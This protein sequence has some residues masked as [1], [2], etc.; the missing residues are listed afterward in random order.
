[1][2]AA[3]ANAPRRSLAAPIPQRNRGITG[4]AAGLATKEAT[5]Q[6]YRLDD[7][8]GIDGECSTC[9]LDWRGIETGRSRQRCST[10]VAAG[11]SQKVALETEQVRRPVSAAAAAAA[12]AAI[13]AGAGHAVGR[14]GIGRSQLRAQ[15]FDFLAIRFGL[16][17][18]GLEVGNLPGQ[19]ANLLAVRPGLLLCLLELPSEAGYLVAAVGC[20]STASDVNPRSSGTS[21]KAALE[22][23][24]L[25][26]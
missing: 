4:N 19:I 13:G 22:L 7:V 12:A 20:T 15:V 8:L 17:V 23:G 11:G 18:L 16:H 5:R 24:N 25:L 2:S 6:G 9:R 14:S 3:T 10:A 1:M 26:Y 21:T